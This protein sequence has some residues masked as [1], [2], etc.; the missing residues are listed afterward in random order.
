M[1]IPQARMPAE[2]RVVAKPRRVSQSTRPRIPP[3]YCVK[4]RKA[5]IK[6]LSKMIFVRPGSS[7]TSTKGVDRA[8]ERADWLE[9][10]QDRVAEPD[11]GKKRDVDS[12][13]LQ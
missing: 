12:E 2:R 10:E 8:D 7:N 6:A 13:L 11:A 5:P 1:P 9:P 3:E 4:V